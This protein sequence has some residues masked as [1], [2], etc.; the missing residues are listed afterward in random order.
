MK[1]I[2]KTNHYR[3]YGEYTL[4]TGGNEINEVVIRS[5][6]DVFVRLAVDYLTFMKESA[7]P[8]S[9][10]PWFK[11]ADYDEDGENE[12]AILLNHRGSNYDVG[13]LLL[14]DNSE[15]GTLE[16]YN[17]EPSVYRACQKERVGVS[18]QKD[19]KLLTLDGV[20]VGTAP[21][22]SMDYYYIGGSWVYIE[23]AESTE[24]CD[25]ALIYEYI[26]YP[27]VGFTGYFTGDAFLE[28]WII[29]EQAVGR[30]FL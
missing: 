19:Y 3:I 30:L 18:E 5:D 13:I 1:L 28:K 27:Y 16:V 8:G 4:D 12:L 15:Q 21:Q 10:T 7:V 29:W 14:A 25:F 23:E 22:L 17:L 26:V 20:C 6:E 11:E 24:N 9:S 2:G